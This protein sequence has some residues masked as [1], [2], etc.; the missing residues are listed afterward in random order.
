[1]NK[2]IE[3][4]KKAFFINVGI[5]LVAFGTHIFRVPN[6][7]V[8]GGITGLSQTL[9]YYTSFS[10]SDLMLILN[11]VVIILGLIF[12]G[13]KD[14]VGIL[15]GSYMLSFMMKFLEI[16]FPISEPLTNDGFI[17]IIFAVFVPSIGSAI[18]YR[19]QLNTGGTEI[20]AKIITKFVDLKM[21]I[22]LM[23]FDFVVVAFAGITFGVEIFLYSTLGLLLRTYIVDLVLDSLYLTKVFNIITDNPDEISNYINTELKHGTTIINAHGGYTYEEKVIVTTTLYRR[24]AAKLQIYLDKNHPKAFTTITN[25]SKVI[26]RGFAR[27]Q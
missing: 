12:L 7:F 2:V 17:E 24:D 11:T 18:L 23:F 25:S 5:F 19:E 8:F 4:L 10:L 9:V 16:F 20:L 27:S 22:V 15:Y 6:N 14:M 1:M 3:F 26:G 21:H 13:K